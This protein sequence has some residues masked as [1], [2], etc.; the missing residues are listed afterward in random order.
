[1]RGG[2]LALG[3]HLE[4]DR[5]KLARRSP[6]TL[7]G[8][9]C[10]PLAKRPATKWFVVIEGPTIQDDDGVGRTEVVMCESLSVNT[11]G[12]RACKGVSEVVG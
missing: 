8:D 5:C 1:M 2:L 6:P 11:K 7:L 4:P 3:I 10:L 9:E 12:K